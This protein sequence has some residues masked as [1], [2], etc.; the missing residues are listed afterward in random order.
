MG[1]GTQDGSEV[2]AADDPG[3]GSQPP[4]ALVVVRNWV[5]HGQ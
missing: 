2:V 1:N 3:R 4:V 5:A